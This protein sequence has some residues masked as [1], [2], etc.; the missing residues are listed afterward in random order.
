MWFTIQTA[1]VVILA[2]AGVAAPWV[3]PMLK[4]PPPSTGAFTGALIAAA[5][6]MLG[7]LLTRLVTRADKK[8]SDADRRLAIKTLI[9]AEL[10]NVSAGYISLQR[11]IE[12]AQGTIEAGGSVPTRVDFS[13]E[14]P[15]SM[16]FTSALGIELLIL[17][18]KEIDVLSTLESNMALTRGQLQEFTTGKRSFNLLTVL[19]LG[20]AIAHDM[21]ILAQGF[22]KLAPLRKLAVQNQPPEL[23]PVLLRRLAA[24]LNGND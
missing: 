18:P 6:T 12:A 21:D 8:S 10:V 19:S 4:L 20:Q 9:T 22:E 2:A 23:A 15:R 14:T 11:T 5:A 16:P 24:R 7:A 1:L 13:N 17:S 3:G